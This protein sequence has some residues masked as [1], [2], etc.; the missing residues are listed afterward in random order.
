MLDSAYNYSSQ[1]VLFK[2]TLTHGKQTFRFDRQGAL[3]YFAGGDPAY[4]DDAGFALKGWKTCRPEVR[5]TFTRG[6]VALAM[7]NVYVTD[8]QG[9]EVMV[10]KTFGYVRDGGSLKIVLHHSSLPYTREK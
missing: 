5:E 7:G 4:P 10:D 6:S 8:A 1:P 3:A 2:P 9:A